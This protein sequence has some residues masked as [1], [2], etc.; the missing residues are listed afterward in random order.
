MAI[1][2]AAPPPSPP[3]DLGDG[4]GLDQPFTAT[5][6]NLAGSGQLCYQQAGD[7]FS[8]AQRDACQSYYIGVPEYVA[9][10]AYVPHGSNN[11]RCT[12]QSPPFYQ[13]GSVRPPLPP[14]PTVPPT[15]PSYGASEPTEPPTHPPTHPTSSPTVPPTAPSYGASEPTEPPTHP[16]TRPTSSPTGPP[17]H[18]PTEPTKPPT[19]PPTQPPTVPPASLSSSPQPP[20]ASSPPDQALTLPPPQPSPP[21]PP[22]VVTDS[23]CGLNQPFTATKTNLWDTREWCYNAA[24]TGPYS[25]A[26]QNACESHYVGRPDYSAECTYVLAGG[27]YRCKLK[28]PIYYPCTGTLSP[29]PPPPPSP[30]VA[31]STCGLN[32]PYTTTKTNLWDTGEW[33]YNAADT[34][35]YSIAAENACE[36]HYVGRSD[37][38]AECTYVLVGDSYRCK[39]KLPIYY[40]C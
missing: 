22:P 40:P 18:P 10:C 2:A 39:L 1:Q 31:G 16:P 12:M 26:A 19:Q 27:S 32:Q 25:T 23:T 11:Y 38:S 29:P 37:Y 24:D 28:L 20:S 6:T 8:T 14:L 3:L 36:S 21:P 4:C 33:C 13:C 9:E 35:P 30:L 7:D 34:G 5:K 17:T 15:A